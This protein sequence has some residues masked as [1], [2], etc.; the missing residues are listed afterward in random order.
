MASRGRRGSHADWPRPLSV[1][2]ARGDRGLMSAVAPAAPAEAPAVEAAAPEPTSAK[3]N[4]SSKK[5]NKD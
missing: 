2:R 1:R 3:G 5:S 4:R